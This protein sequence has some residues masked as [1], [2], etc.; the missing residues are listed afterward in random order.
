VA[1]RG[2]GVKPFFEPEN[3]NFIEFV[4]LKLKKFFSGP[5]SVR[6]AQAK[7]DVRLCCSG[8]VFRGL[9]DHVAPPLEGWH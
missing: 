8:C 9:G 1:S 6:L 7:W 2:G 4:A 5:K 3:T